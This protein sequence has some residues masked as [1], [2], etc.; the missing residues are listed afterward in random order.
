MAHPHPRTETD[1]KRDEPHRGHTRRG[2]SPAGVT[3]TET[4]RTEV[5][6][7][8]GGER[9]AGTRVLRVEFPIRQT[10]TVTETEGGGWCLR[11]AGGLHATGLCTQKGR[12]GW[13]LSPYAYFTTIKRKKNPVS[14]TPEKSG[15]EPE[16]GLISGRHRRG[17]WERMRRLPHGEATRTGERGTWSPRGRRGVSKER[18][19]LGG[20]VKG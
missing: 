12:S 20:E 4:E 11:H 2:S 18:T 16:G 3:F 5:P 17:V 10:G 14:T 19:S 6:G 13:D 15:S 8:R 7:G 1:A 9:G